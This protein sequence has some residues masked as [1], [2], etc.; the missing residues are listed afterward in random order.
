MTRRD[1]NYR[2]TCCNN[3]LTNS[4]QKTMLCDRCTPPPP[5]TERERLLQLL[6]RGQRTQDC[7]IE[8]INDA[9]IFLLEN[10]S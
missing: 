9:I 8:D 5:P 1:P 2:C 4:E 10:S 7:C 3:P 6:R